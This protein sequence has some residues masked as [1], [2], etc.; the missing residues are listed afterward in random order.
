MIRIILFYI[1]CLLSLNIYASV[2]LDL[3]KITVEKGLSHSDVR[4]ICQDDY[5]YIW[6]AT[7]K[8]LNYFDG[9]KIEVFDKSKGLK[10][11]R[12]VEMKKDKFGY[13]WLLSEESGI[14]SFHPLTHKVQYHQL[15]NNK[16][17]SELFDIQNLSL[18][19]MT[20][21]KEGNCL[22]AVATNSKVY[23]LP[24]KKD[25]NIKNIQEIPFNLPSQTENFVRSIHSDDQGTIWIG[26]R[27]GL[28]FKKRNNANFKKFKGSESKLKGVRSILKLNGGNYLIGAYNGLFKVSLY[29]QT[30]KKIQPQFPV[31]RI[32]SLLKASDNS[33]W[34][35]TTEG[36]L[37]MNK[38][39]NLQ[40][41]YLEDNNLSS[42]VVSLFEDKSNT[43]WIG[44]NS[45]G[46]RYVD[47]K[48]SNFKHIDITNYN[49]FD[50]TY[51]K[52]MSEIDDYYILGSSN[53]VHFVTKDFKKDV[54]H[55]K[56]K[57]DLQCSVNTI[58]VSESKYVILG[59]AGY[60]LY[61][62][63]QP[64]DKVENISFHQIKFPKELEHPKRFHIRKVT[65]DKYDNIWIATNDGGIYCYNIH[66]KKVKHIDRVKNISLSIIN[67]MFYEADKDLLWVG[68]RNKGLIKLQLQKD[69]LVS[70]KQ[71]MHSIGD[72]NTLSS[73]FVF[74]IVRDKDNQIWAGTIGGGLNCLIDEERGIFQRYNHSN[75]LF[76]DDIEGLLVDNTNGNIWIAGT[77]ITSF[78][79]ESKTFTRYGKSDGIHAENGF[80]VNTDF[81]DNHGV[82]FFGGVDGLTL[83]DINNWKKETQKIRL[84]I[85]GLEINHQKLVF[86]E[87]Y[88][89]RVLLDSQLREKKSYL[90]YPNEKDIS[91]S[92]IGN[93]PSEVNKIEYQY[94]LEGYD[95]DWIETMTSN[96]NNSAYY[97]NLSSGRYTFKVR[98]KLHN[99]PWSDIKTISFKIEKPWWQRW[100]SIASFVCIV[101]LVILLINY[102]YIQQHKLKTQLVFAQ[103]QREK[104][105]ELIE[106][107]L[108][109]F[110]NV[111]H[112]LRTPLTLMQG[113]L[114][115]VVQN[116]SISPDVREKISL[117]YQQTNKLLRL[118]NELMDFRK[119]D[120][121]LELNNTTFEFIHFIENIF[122][123]FK[124]KAKDKGIDF[125]LQVPENPIKVHYDA[126]KIESVIYNL[127]SNA[128]KFTE[129][130]GTITLNVL[131]DEAN[132]KLILKVID[133]GLGIDENALDKIFDRFYQT[134]NANSINIKGTGLGLSI[135]KSV[136]EAHEGDIHV[137]SEK[138]KGTSFI[139]D[140][141]LKDVESKEVMPQSYYVQNDVDIEEVD[142]V[143]FE[144]QTVLLVEDNEEILQY[145]ANLLKDTCKIKKAENGKEA[146]DILHT[147][148]NISLVVSDVMMP[149]MNGTEL[150]HHIKTNEQLWH[151]PI[152]LLTAKTSLIHQ[153][154]GLETGADDYITKPF[155]PSILKQKVINVLKNK[156][157]VMQMYQG[158]MQLQKPLSKYSK[159]MEDDFLEK[160]IEI[161]EK[162][163]SDPNLNVQLLVDEMAMSQSALYKKMKDVTGK[164][165]VEFIKDVR[166]RK[167]GELLLSSNLKIFEIAYE[168][169]FNDVKYFR[170]CFKDHYGMSASEY[171][172]QMSKITE[173]E[174][175]TN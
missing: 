109:F 160:T 144:N 83:I 25:G 66:T 17:G 18:K 130:K 22:Y 134:K 87:E 166:M 85:S 95:E 112:D 159:E 138:G 174:E 133:N 139:I 123:S 55:A 96:A 131:V 92:F 132:K 59:T 115:E 151:V 28:F 89:G 88:N 169:G 7:L 62:S 128:F 65:T 118:V 6:I 30:I 11:N 173:Q 106:Q 10:S 43:V 5:G 152:Y 45:I 71:Y 153:L 32:N 145:L 113:P 39:E 101:V 64:F 141:P 108:E 61:I 122:N 19:F 161:V 52:S 156:E 49:N 4:A 3:Q 75:G 116:K 74:S 94:L 158:V 42:N 24:I 53:G 60:G 150:C 129:T 20:M 77:T 125:K 33:I 143:T 149:E 170:K 47:L 12:L 104:D 121:T 51:S 114:D 79:K 82:M 9:E 54:K 56:L 99:G 172:K 124:L 163:L 135:A 15:V 80:K 73:N 58:T 91:I 14:S 102:N 168:I 162:N 46:V 57:S 100:Y 78:D 142:G 50:F 23:K 26:K 16:D 70:S 69:E 68:T 93:S 76:E 154:E 86:D 35:G 126:E 90:L 67:S 44:C 21:N 157:H 48:E 175:I 110:T 167:A 38:E 97:S 120:K 29:K 36:I 119:F 2:P 137:E 27:N 98:G 41:Y 31:R 37:T 117:S 81:K 40:F 107:K 1:V 111:G 147:D 63:N 171:I 155:K 8:G 105:E 13:L 146:L 127:L 148:K 165:L 140:L 103:N 136:I 34:I 72:E 84:D 164:S